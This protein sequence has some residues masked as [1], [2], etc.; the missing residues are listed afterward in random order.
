MR[1]IAVDIEM[2]QP[3]G[4]IIQIG[5]VAWDTDGGLLSTFNRFISHNV[6]WDYELQNNKGTLKNLLP[7]NQSTIDRLGDPKDEVIRDFWQWTN[8]VQ[9]GKRFVQWGSG[10]IRTILNQTPKDIMVAKRYEIIDAK[11]IYKNMVQ[12]A[13]G[14]PKKYALKDASYYLLEA[15]NVPWHNAYTD[16]F[17]TARVYYEVF[18][19]I[20]LNRIIKENI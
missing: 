8:N 1:F 17:W 5:A 15:I 19:M 10:D 20:K 12:P 6:N 11:V 14:L 4:D 13:M 16:A 2:D 18:K 3:S 7:F 9:C